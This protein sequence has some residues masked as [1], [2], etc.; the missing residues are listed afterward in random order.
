M[1]CEVSI[2][3]ALMFFRYILIEIIIHKALILFDLVNEEVTQ[4]LLVNLVSS[5]FNLEI[6]ASNCM[7]LGIFT[8]LFV[9][10]L[11]FFFLILD[12]GVACFNPI[13]L[14]ICSSFLCFLQIVLVF[15]F[16]FLPCM[17]NM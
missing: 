3:L 14:S 16:S 17:N 6:W 1:T 13:F 7:L 11:Q 4:R 8:C 2:F 10:W 12:F 15:T 9:Y 5:I